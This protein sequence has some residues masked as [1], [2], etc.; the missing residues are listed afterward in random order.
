VGE[1]S[2]LGNV[3]PLLL[4][5]DGTSW[6]RLPFEPVGQALNAVWGSSSSDVWILSFAHSAFTSSI[7][8]Y[9][10]A[11]WSKVVGVVFQNLFLSVWGSSASDVWAVGP[12]NIDPIAQSTTAHYNGT[13]WTDGANGTPRGLSSVWGASPFD[14]W[15]VG[16]NGTIVHYNGSAWSRVA[17]GS[18]PVVQSLN[19]V[20]GTSTSNV[21]AVGD[22]GTILHWSP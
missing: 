5:Y 14:I 18:T 12:D 10:G 21:W 17:S 13:S 2:D 4:H 11:S 15:A 22:G 19:G 7:Y 9:D 16:L 8:H 6:S 1:I 3:G 20:W